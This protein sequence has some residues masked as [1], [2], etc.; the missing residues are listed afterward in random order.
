MA[1]CEGMLNALDAS[2]LFLYQFEPTAETCFCEFGMVYFVEQKAVGLKRSLGFG[3]GFGEFITDG[4]VGSDELDAG[5]FESFVELSYTRAESVAHRFVAAAEQ[6][7][8]L[9][10][11]IENLQ[12]VEK[13]I[14]V[15][16]DITRSPCGCAED[17]HVVVIDFVG[18]GVGNV[19]YV[20][21]VHSEELTDTFS[22]L[23]SGSCGGA[24][25]LSLIHI[26]E[27]TRRS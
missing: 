19:M 11:E 25:K 23:F 20:S 14:P 5:G 26:S 18:R 21:L 4:V 27:P 12:T 15:I 16:F 22:N 1:K 3:F 9:T 10:F 2:C 6:G 13:I 24:V 8:L 17:K 7:C